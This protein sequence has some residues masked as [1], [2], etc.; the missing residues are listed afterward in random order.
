MRELLLRREPNQNVRQITIFD[1]YLD[2]LDEKFEKVARDPQ[3]LAMLA[4]ALNSWSTTQEFIGRSTR[5]FSPSR[6]IRL[7]EHAQ[8]M[9][10]PPRKRIP[11][12]E[13]TPSRIIYQEGSLR[14]KFYSSWQ[15]PARGR[16]VICPS[17]INRPYILDLG[18]GRSL[19]GYF[20]RRGFEVMLLDWGHPTSKERDL[21]LKQLIHDRIP[22]ALHS[23][24]G[25]S[26]CDESLPRTLIG[27]CLGGN[28]ALKLLENCP[29][30]FDRLV[31]ITTPI[32]SRNDALL[33]KWAQIPEWNPQLYARLF[34]H[35]PW[36]VLH[37]SFLL[38]RPSLTPR[39]WL[40]LISQW[41]DRDFLASWLQMEIWSN[42]GVSIPSQLFQDLLLPMYRE[43][44][45]Y[46]SSQLRLP[47]FSLIAKDDHIVPAKAAIAIQETHPLCRHE[48]HLAAGGHVGAVFSA[49]TRREI[50]PA[51][52][53]FMSDAQISTS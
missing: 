8:K 9:R 50:W 13:S 51:L 45:M 18:R 16:I 23:I 35:I 28:I 3:V 5:P 27:H 43:N 33:T 12:L 40:K 48:L 4:H 47:I 46:R 1:R 37:A 25:F 6:A 21:G 26:K 22:R 42:D 36:S 38:Q 30:E 29:Q 7:L 53:S 10:P 39:R 34:E 52:V 17:L 49:K 31:L 32:D 14:V 24:R 41:R 20:V 15:A 19:I 2:Q 44:A 11:L